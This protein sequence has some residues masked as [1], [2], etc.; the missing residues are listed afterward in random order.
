[1]HDKGEGSD[2]LRVGGWLPDAPEHSG[3]PLPDPSPTRPL[4]APVLPQAVSTPAVY[5]AGRFNVLPRTRVIAAAVAALALSITTVAWLAGS[6]EPERTPAS[7]RRAP[8]WPG[9]PYDSWAPPTPEPALSTTV[10]SVPVA[11]PDSGDA[12]APAATTPRSPAAKPVIPAVSLTDGPIPAVVD[13]SAEGTRDWMHWGLTDA[14]SVNRRSGGKGI[15]DLGGS[16]R[17]RYDNNPQLYSW[18][19]GSPAASATRTP[20]G[21]YSCGQGAT[22]TLRAPAGPAMRT[23][24]LY[25]GV[26]MASGRLTVTVDGVTATRALENRD[27]ISTRRFEVR[28]RAPAG[29]KLTVTW[30][31]TA[32]SHPGCGNID[33]QAATLS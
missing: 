33:L 6:G 19:G 32:V 13:L 8:L 15:E 7:E 29:S 27:T 31:A 14:T 11:D 20:T 24:R 21:V 18:T 9:V 17:G 26:W 25:A 4:P 5:T 23:L 10:P 12:P 2:R 22:I 28:Y 16:P 1:V 3:R 30:T